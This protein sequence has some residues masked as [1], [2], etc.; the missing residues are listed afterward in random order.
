MLVSTFVDVIIAMELSERVLGPGIIMITK[1]L[2]KLS[3][4]YVASLEWGNPVFGQ[5]LCTDTY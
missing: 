3:P 4:V 1:F 2:V 5:I